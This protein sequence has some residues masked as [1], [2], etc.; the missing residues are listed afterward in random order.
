MPKYAHILI[1]SVIFLSPVF[2]NSQKKFLDSS[3]TQ[4]ITNAGMTSA[5]LFTGAIF[6]DQKLNNFIQNNQSGFLSD[7]ANSFYRL[8]DKKILVP[9][10]ALIYG[11]SW[12]LK[13]ERMQHTSLNAFKSILSTAIL[14]E[15]GKQVFGRT[16]PYMDKGAYHFRSF[17][18]FRNNSNH[19]KSLP[20]GHASLSF[21][22][23]TPYAEEYSRWLYLIPTSVAFNRVYKNKHW[24]SDVILGS[25]I[26]WLS[27]YF[28]HHKNE[29][30]EITLN[31]II[32]KF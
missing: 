6:Y 18:I 24:L 22:F 16:R 30:I 9:L 28:F 17:P 23:I 26:G 13:N 19:Y 20:S 7:Y 32:I 5:V 12:A 15:G 10:N 11:G 2:A 4:T 27:G 1:F 14:T 3:D 21:A 8:G 25:T 29:H 31:S